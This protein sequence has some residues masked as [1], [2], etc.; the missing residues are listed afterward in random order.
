ME[1]DN[2]RYILA[3]AR[4]KSI[5]GAARQLK[6]HHTTVFRRLNALEE[7]LGV[8]V[9]ERLSTEYVLTLAGEQMYQNA[10][11]IEEKIATVERHISGQDRRLK[12]SIRVTTTASLL[13]YLLTPCFAA[14]MR[15]YPEIELEILESNQQY[16]LTKRDA[17]IAIRTT[18][19]PPEHL[20]GR[21]I[22]KAAI[23]IYA[24]KNYLVANEKIDNITEH[25]WIGLE[26]SLARIM[27]G[28]K[29]RQLLPQF[30]FQYQVNTLMGILYALLNDMGI[31]L[32][33]CYMGNSEPN[34]QSVYPIIPEL[35]KDLWILTHP[36]IR[37]V[38]RISIFVDFIAEALKSKIELIEG[39][40]SVTRKLKL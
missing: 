23:A 31:G 7:S 36:D 20:V 26:E 5:A 18:N 6:V 2:L 10:V 22:G 9:F 30:E 35:A 8:R 17:D 19:N 1:W 33:F 3:I 28:N 25:T 24:S 27:Y 11:E 29:L 38:A 39:I 32:L 14:F 13:R 12:G 4:A 34:L 40:D 37:H 16:N 15:E 21:K